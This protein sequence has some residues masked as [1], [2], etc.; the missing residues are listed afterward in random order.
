MSVEQSDSLMAWMRSNEAAI[1]LS[2][3]S[4]S[5]RECN[6]PHVAASW[7][8]GFDR[9][10]NVDFAAVPILTNL[11]CSSTK[12]LS[13]TRLKLQMVPCWSALLAST[14][15]LTQLNL[16]DIRLQDP[17]SQSMATALMGLS[18]LTALQELGLQRVVWAKDP[19]RT[20]TASLPK[21]LLPCL[22]SLER[23]TLDQHLALDAVKSLGKVRGLQEL[24]LDF[25]SVH[26][27]GVAAAWA[28]LQQLP[29]LTSLEMR[30]APSGDKPTTAALM[31]E[32]DVNAALKMITGLRKPHI[33]KPTR[34]EGL[35]R[36]L[37][38]PS[39]LGLES[40]VVITFGIDANSVVEK[41]TQLPRMRHLHLSDDAAWLLADAHGAFTLNTGLQHLHL[42][43]V[44]DGGALP[45]LLP[46]E[47]PHLTYLYLGNYFFVDASDTDL[48]VKKC[49]ALQ[50]LHTGTLLQDKSLATLAGLTGLTKLG[51]D[52]TKHAGAEQLVQLSRLREIDIRDS[53]VTPFG[54]NEPVLL[55]ILSRKTHLALVSLGLDT[56]KPFY[57]WLPTSCQ[58][59]SEQGEV[60][61]H[62]IHQVGLLVLHTQSNA[63]LCIGWLHD[64]LAGG[65]G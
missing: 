64:R 24:V 26:M 55:H 34:Y 49:P 6:H 4:M 28:A 22:R 9:P 32:Y 39:S 3:I 11:A 65:M 36:Q 38:M 17:A 10:S 16:Q 50:R 37:I 31:D 42:A 44:I 41:V 53:G 14:A 40:L 25:T 13:A 30:G 60:T 8:D 27:K 7:E 29:H 35:E 62:F 57:Q 51:I 21:H 33:E 48:L 58:H 18:A 5:G 52:C 43:H 20:V 46:H 59:T 1:A 54:S 15:H 63:C 19:T 45:H 2:S 47:L 56:R 61:A 12:D 23:L